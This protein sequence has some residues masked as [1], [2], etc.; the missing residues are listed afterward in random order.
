MKKILSLFKVSFF[1]EAVIGLIG[2]CFPLFYDYN[3]KVLLI[4]LFVFVPAIISL[5]IGLRLAMATGKGR[6]L[7]D[8][9]NIVGHIANT[10]K[11]LAS[12]PVI[13][14]GVR[15]YIISLKAYT[16]GHEKMSLYVISLMLFILWCL[17][18]LYN[19]AAYILIAKAN[20]KAT[21]TALYD[22]W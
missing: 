7:S 4:F 20:K 5:L 16:S 9:L 8:E 6:R 1:T 13:V 22:F 21:V 10:T 17:A 12:L 3:L 19:F 15:I 18:C 11:L 14:F 2:L